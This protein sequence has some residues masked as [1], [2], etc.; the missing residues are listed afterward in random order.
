MEYLYTNNTGG[1]VYPN[2]KALAPGE[3]ITLH[4]DSCPEFATAGLDQAAAVKPAPEDDADIGLHSM[5]A[6][7]AKDF[8]AE[9]AAAPVD[10]LS[11]AD[12]KRLAEIESAKAEPRKTVLGAIQ[13][14]LLAR[15][16]AAK[17]AVDN[18]FAASGSAG[19]NA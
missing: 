2:G 10:A 16:G 11:D 9:L 6:Q 12:L 18:G 19:A 3:S 14:A 4:T 15:A 5:L 13:E 1:Y 8:I 17:T 7:P